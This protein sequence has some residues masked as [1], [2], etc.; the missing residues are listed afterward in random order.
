MRQRKKPE[1]IITVSRPV[2]TEEER[3]KRMEAIKKAAVELVLSTE[4]AK[5][6][7]EL[8]QNQNPKG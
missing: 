3:A 4:S 6:Q 1:F 8:S 7:R 5:R 2:L